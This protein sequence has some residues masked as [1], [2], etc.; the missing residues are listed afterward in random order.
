MIETKYINTKKRRDM[1]E[2]TYGG[3]VLSWRCQFFQMLARSGIRGR[4]TWSWKKARGA[5]RCTWCRKKWAWYVSVQSFQ[6][7]RQVKHVLNFLRKKLWT[8]LAMFMQEVPIFSW[9]SWIFLNA[10]RILCRPF[11]S[12]TEYLDYPLWNHIICPLSK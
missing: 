3:Q 10:D 12:D 6:K 4:R 1:Y 8:Y 2:Y 7:K 5:G 11:F 9:S